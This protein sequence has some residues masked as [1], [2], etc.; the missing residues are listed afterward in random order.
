MGRKKELMEFSSGEL[1]GHNSRPG[2]GQFSDAFRKKNDFFS[3]IL[4][5]GK[6]DEMLEAQLP[7][8]QP[9]KF[10]QRERSFTAKSQSFEDKGIVS[11]L[12]SGC[13]KML[14]IVAG[15]QFQFWLVLVKVGTK[16]SL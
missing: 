8:A 12:S 4:M 15:H 16:F 14:R 1:P 3:A 9:C 13:N 10:F 11:L 2:I 5:G 6:L 7:G